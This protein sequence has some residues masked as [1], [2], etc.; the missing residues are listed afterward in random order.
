MTHTGLQAMV[1]THSHPS[2]RGVAYGGDQQMAWRRKNEA[3]CRS[4]PA[5]SYLIPWWQL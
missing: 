1:P 5:G 4:T 3:G 2:M